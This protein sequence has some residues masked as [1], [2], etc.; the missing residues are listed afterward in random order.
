[1]NIIVFFQIFHTIS[2]GDIRLYHVYRGYSMGGFVYDFL[3][4]SEDVISGT[5]ERSE[6]VADIISERIRICNY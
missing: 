3:S 5:S 1:M 4:M 2:L 6:R